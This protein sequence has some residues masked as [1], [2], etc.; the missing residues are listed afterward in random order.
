MRTLILGGSGM[1]G[2]HLL[3]VFQEAGHEVAATLRYLK[4]VYALPAFSSEHITFSMMWM[5]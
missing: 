3:K 2:Y 5:C 4:E 1:L